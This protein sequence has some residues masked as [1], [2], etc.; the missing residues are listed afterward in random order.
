MWSNFV[1][2]WFKNNIYGNKS[3]LSILN[4]QFTYDNN[5]YKFVKTFLNSNKL[6]G[7]IILD[8]G[9]GNKPYRVLAD[10]TIWL[11][12][13]TSPNSLR[14]FNYKENSFFPIKNQ[15]VDLVI[16]TEV[17]EHVENDKFLVEEIY[18]CLKI[19]GTAIFTTPF[20][21][22]LHG[23][24]QDFRRLTPYGME[25]VFNSKMV[26]IKTGLIGGPWSSIILLILNL[27]TPL[28]F[29]SKAATLFTPI[30]FAC[31]L[32]LNVLAIIFDK[33]FKNDSFGQASFA[34]ITKV[35]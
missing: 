20:L 11:G 18:R 8:V 12:L 25:S 13:D 2:R 30:Y 15:S 4:P 28:F 26:V 35:E 29:K 3:F 22:P 16:C 27:I 24:P 31:N 5:L 10:E 33:F 34:I 7:K 17:L 14:D 32:L 23:V 19:N 21:F 1:I 9:C 6:N